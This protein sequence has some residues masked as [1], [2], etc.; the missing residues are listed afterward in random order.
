MTLF[1]LLFIVSF[2][3]SVILIIRIGYLAV[4]G[5]K[6][7]VKTTARFLGGFVGIYA[8]IVVQVSLSSARKLV[9]IGEPRCFDEWCIAVTAVSRQHAIGDVKA[10]G[11]YYRRQVAGQQPFARAA[12]AGNRCVHLSG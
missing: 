4:R 1:D 5:R 9:G 3:T 8:A 10:Q 12:A 11:V 2:V 7:S 6:T